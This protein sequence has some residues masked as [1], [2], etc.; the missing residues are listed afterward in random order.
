VATVNF[1]FISGGSVGQILNSGNQD[2]GRTLSLSGIAPE[3]LI[4]RL[5]RRFAFPELRLVGTD[6]L[7]AAAIF[8]KSL[9]P[10]EFAL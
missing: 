8:E 10:K 5:S 3:F 4:S 9:L 7:W 1:T 2:F 6:M